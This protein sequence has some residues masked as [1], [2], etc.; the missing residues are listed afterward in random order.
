M[1]RYPG[2]QQ[3]LPFLL[4]EVD[5]K[6]RRMRQ[7]LR[8]CHARDTD[9]R[10]KYEIEGMGIYR[11]KF[12]AHKMW[13]PTAAQSFI[14][15]LLKSLKEYLPRQGADTLSLHKALEAAMTKME[16]ARTTNN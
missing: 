6:A 15:A 4:R 16:A 10:T 1:G 9:F 7:E 11:R 5:P 2:A 12:F 8:S 13:A 14:A 3:N